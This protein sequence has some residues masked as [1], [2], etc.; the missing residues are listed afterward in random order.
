MPS[1]D[2]ELITS[3][4]RYILM[5]LKLLLCRS[6]G[7]DSGVTLCR[8]DRLTLAC[9]L[10]IL[11][12]TIQ[13]HVQGSIKQ[14]KDWDSRIRLLYCGRRHQM[15]TFRSAGFPTEN[16]AR[17][18]LRSGGI[19]LQ[20]IGEVYWYNFFLWSDYLALCNGWESSR[21]GR[22]AW[23]ARRD[24]VDLSMVDRSTRLIVESIQLRRLVY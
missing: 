15:Y 3:P 9:L 1:H 20:R 10:Y 17:E 8:V 16:I 24:L 23:G 6:L 18:L 12:N 19:Q 14:I 5:P 13:W 7:I 4:D 2:V 11:D 22:M 21:L